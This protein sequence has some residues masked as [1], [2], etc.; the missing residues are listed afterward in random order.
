MDALAL[1]VE[2]LWGPAMIDDAVR[3]HVGAAP[4]GRWRQQES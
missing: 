3:V 4:S 2:Q 1:M